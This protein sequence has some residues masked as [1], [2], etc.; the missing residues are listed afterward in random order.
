[1]TIL[2]SWNKTH[3]H[4]YPCFSWNSDIIF[5]E[6][7]VFSMYLLTLLISLCYLLH[8]K[9]LITL[10]RMFPLSIRDKK[11]KKIG[12]S[13]IPI[14]YFLFGLQNQRSL[15]LAYWVVC[16]WL[17][18]MF[19]GGALHLSIANT[20]WFG[21]HPVWLLIRT[22]AWENLVWFF[23]F[24]LMAWNVHLDFLEQVSH[25]HTSL[26]FM[27]FWHHICWVCGVFCVSSCSANFT[28]ISFS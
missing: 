25:T 21:H 2:I 16:C 10:C 3:T 22:V 6:C 17:R 14:S 11:G 4:T 13:V 5:V 20:C 12:D 9:L 18:S 27:N 15:V 8:E 26:F 28:V 24:L 23:M 19:W 1:M 7:A